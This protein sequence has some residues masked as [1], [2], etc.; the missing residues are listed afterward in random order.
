MDIK[1]QIDSIVEM[2]IL[3]QSTYQGLTLDE[4]AEELGRPRRAIERMK[5]FFQKYYSDE[6]EEVSHPTERKKYWRLK[7]CSMGLI[8]LT[9]ED[10]AKLESI[11]DLIKNDIEKRQFSRIIRKLVAINS[12]KTHK[13]DIDVL[14]ESQGYAVRQRVKE[15]IE[16]EIFEKIYLAI[17]A[18]CK[19]NMSYTLSNGEKYQVKMSPYG[20]KIGDFHYLIGLEHYKNPKVKTYKM[21]RIN[22]IRVLD[23]EDAELDEK[24]NLQEFCKKSFGIYTSELEDIEIKFSKEVK[25]DVINY[26]FH[27]TQ[28]FEEQE[29]GSII[30]KFKA[31]GYFEIITE[32]LKWRDNIKVIAP[33][34]L[35]EDYVQTIKDMYKNIGE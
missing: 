10:I 28:I 9:D 18:G 14:L 17:K 11:K 3:L 27:P 5:A 31:S 35:K 22:W 13:T 32:L 16:P 19:I 33:K 4:I 1:T 26:E 6:L 8:K 21:S 29:D 34:K 2:A 12:N 30:L 15:N 25:N 7:P 24:F 23:E 20:I